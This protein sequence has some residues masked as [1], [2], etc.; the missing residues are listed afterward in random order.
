M[1]LK[2]ILDTNFLMIP[3]DFKIDIFQELEGYELITLEECI[4]ELKRINPRVVELVRQ[5]VSVVRESF[6]SHNV[7]DKIIE[8][9]AKHNAYIATS[10]KM[11][12]KRAVASGIPVVFMR[13]NKYLVIPDV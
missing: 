1:C 3:F 7:D 13:Q 6:K 8:L 10:D 11:L 5:H 12:K 2:I 9:A 4:E